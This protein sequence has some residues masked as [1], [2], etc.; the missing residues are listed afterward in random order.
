MASRAP[1]PVAAHTKVRVD[2]PPQEGPA[3][4][5]LLDGRFLLHLLGNG[6]GPFL[7]LVRSASLLTASRP[8][9]DRSHGQGLQE[10]FSPPFV[11][12]QDPSKTKRLYRG[13]G[14]ASTG[15][16]Q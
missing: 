5:T 7:R 15:D 6:G 9:Q 12:F 8:M 4:E 16:G 1:L 13:D 3:A 14:A 11:L 2:R 10:S